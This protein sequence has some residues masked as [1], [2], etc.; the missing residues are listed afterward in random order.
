MP[1]ASERRP[2]HQRPRVLPWRLAL[3]VG[4]GSTAAV[5]MIGTQSTVASS[6]T[7]ATPSTPTVSSSLF[8]DTAPSLKPVV[9]TPSTGS[10]V[11][12]V[13]GAVAKPGSGPAPSPGLVG[14]GA[15][16]A[17]AGDGIPS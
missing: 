1:T 3:A 6:T 11:H 12:S 15:V 17:L 7:G 8:Q 10:A 9:R 4:A 2:S 14:V 5:L 16:S 13:P